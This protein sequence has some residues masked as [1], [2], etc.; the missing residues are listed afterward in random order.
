MPVDPDPVSDGNLRLELTG[1]GAPIVTV[2]PP[3]YR[4]DDEDYYQAHFRS[5]PDADDWR[6]R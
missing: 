5:C 6:R 1:A 4:R 2:V 3:G